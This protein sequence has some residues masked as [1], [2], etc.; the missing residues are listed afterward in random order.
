MLVGLGGQR[1][2]LHPQALPLGAT[3]EHR[4]P[5]SKDVGGGKTDHHEHPDAEDEAAD[6]IVGVQVP[7]H[8]HGRD[9]GQRHP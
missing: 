6:H 9:V 7:A 4:R 1:R 8:H 3:R 5:P 2:L